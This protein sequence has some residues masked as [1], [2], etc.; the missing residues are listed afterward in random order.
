MQS[1]V[2]L[3]ELRQLPAGDVTSEFAVTDVVRRLR[4]MD[5][6]FF[7]LEVAQAT[8]DAL[9]ALFEARNV[10]DVL[11]QAY[12]MAFTRASQSKSLLEHFEERLDTG[13]SSVVGFVSSLKGKVA[14]L[15]G[16]QLLE[17]Q[18][19][20]YKFEIMPNPNQPVYDLIG[21][22][23]EG[24]EDVLVQVKAGGEGYVGNV[25]D[26]IEETPPDVYFAVSRELYDNVL[27]AKPELSG[28]LIDLHI[29]VTEFTEDIK[30][31]L[32]TLSTNLGIDVP[33]SLGEVLPY[34]GETVLAIK[35]ITQIIST[36]GDLKGIEISN[37]SRIHAIRTLALMAKFGVTQVCALGGGFA[38]TA[39]NPGVGS[40]IGAIGGAGGA[41]LL[42]RL[43]EPRIEEV[44]KTI[45]GGDGDEIFYLMNKSAIDEIGNS[46]AATLVT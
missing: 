32:G 27:E 1:L 19:P 16:V 24:V 33:D 20:G 11:N 13:N 8:E 31:G 18:S 21:R 26:R 25:L 41:M 17:E 40:A 15:K 34:V 3:E 14:E 28:Q 46:L 23:P 4:A 30:S 22:G 44:A 29:N 10:P 45:V 5:R 9:E 39:V 12:E 37:R 2:L 35:L 38:G 6:D 42:N 7:S 43:L 36:E